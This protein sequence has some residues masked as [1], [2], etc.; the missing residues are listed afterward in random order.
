MKREWKIFAAM[1]AVFLVAYF[2]PLSDPNVRVAVVEAFKLLQWYARNHTLACVVPALFIAGGIITFLSQA[3]VMRYLGPN[4]NKLLAY[5]VASVSGA[6]LAVCSC[7]VL[8]MFAGIYRLGAGLGPASAFLYSGPAINVLAV[9][10]TARVLGLSLGLARAVGAV[11]FAF[12]VGLAMAAIFRRGEQE[13]AQAAVQMPEPER[14]KRPLWKTALYFACMVAFLVCSDW[15]NPGDVVVHTTDGQQFR[16][17]T[18]QEMKGEILFQLEEDWGGHASREKV[19]LAKA[20]IANIQEAK[21]WVIAIH[22]VKWYLAGA[23]G[24]AVLLI[25]WR[26]FERAEVKEWMHNTWDFAKL[27]VPLL[28]GGVFV[29]GFI[30][31]LLPEAV[32]ARSVGD[33]SLGSNL[34]ASVIGAVWYFATLTEIPICQTLGKLGMHRGPMLALLLAGPAL[35]LPNMLVIGKVI[36]WRKTLVF[37]AIIVVISTG[38]GMLYGVIAQMG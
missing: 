12:V 23:M 34:V 1:L 7:S 13:K 25:V 3:S 37:C 27:L 4:S 6:V 24:L 17:V 38:V 2:L 11:G 15:Y 33:N 22:R 20:S 14:P 18:L 31:A 30:G 21:T 28:F 5:A 8:P 29:V 9:F 16:A 35:S 19:T 10:L 32:V 26:W 36:G